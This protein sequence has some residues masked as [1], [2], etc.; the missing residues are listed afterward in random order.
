M[1]RPRWQESGNLSC[2]MQ[3][4]LVFTELGPS[5]LMLRGPGGHR[6]CGSCPG[7][8]GP[9]NLL[10]EDLE[11]TGLGEGEG[12]GVLLDVARAHPGRC[13]AYAMNR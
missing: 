4:H 11:R 6:V 1:K 13:E 9:Q 8:T 7:L 10:Q 5:F 12:Q 3:S 2:W